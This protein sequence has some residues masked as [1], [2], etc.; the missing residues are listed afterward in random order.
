MACG[1]VVR[2]RVTG[3]EK[4][5]RGKGGGRGGGG[6]SFKSVHRGRGRPAG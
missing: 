3:E 2:A 4:R 5:K 1:G 6:G